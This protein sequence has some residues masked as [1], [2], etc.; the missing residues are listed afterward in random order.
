M[1]AAPGR[2]AFDGLGRSE[3]VRLLAR[4][5]ELLNDPGEHHER[6]Q[7]CARTM[8]AWALEPTDTNHRAA[9]HAFLAAVNLDDCQHG[10]GHLIVLL[11]HT[12][13]G[14]D[15][16]AAQLCAQAAAS[17]IE[18]IGGIAWAR[19]TID[20]LAAGTPAD[21]R[22]VWELALAGTRIDRAVRAA[23]LLHHP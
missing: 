3:R 21:A 23:G 10:A 18:R 2:A 4:Y 16:E 22:A 7:A 1:S 17:V 5:T 12:A 6:R 8:R 19:H 15:T 13:S 11:G 20:E 9:R 14:N